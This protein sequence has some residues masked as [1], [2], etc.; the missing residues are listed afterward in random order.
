MSFEVSPIT[1]AAATAEVRRSAPLRPRV[2]IIAGSGLGPLA[3]QVEA[4]AHIPYD[5]IPHFPV[6]TVEGH[7]GELV[8]GTIAAQPVVVMRGRFHFYEGYSFL[9]VTFPV[10]VMHA[11]GADTLIVTNAAGGL[12]PD[13]GVGDLMLIQDHISLPAMAGHSPLHGPNDAALG[14]RFPSLVGAYDRDLRRLARH[15]AAGQGLSLREGVYT[16]CA[17]PSFETPAEI[18]FLRLIGGDAVGMST[19]PE[20]TVARHGGMRVLGIS[21][22]TNAAEA[23]SDAVGL[24]GEAGHHEVLASA[25]AA[26][27]RLTALVRGILAAL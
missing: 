24:A 15:V 18:R 4:A 9:E 14:P 20:V 3:E 19:A 5:T 23:N 22:I 13:F 21:L 10:R 6:S 12:N 8:V 1:I 2:A 26:I 16:M 11:L 27:P 25:E 17:G 7:D